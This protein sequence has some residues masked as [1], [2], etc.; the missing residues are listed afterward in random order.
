M[1]KMDF[2]RV[3][4]SLTILGLLLLTAGSCE[5]EEEGGPSIVTDIDGNIYN[6]VTIGTQV[7]MVENLK[8]TR[9]RDGSGIPNVTDNLQWVSDGALKSPAYCNL[10]NYEANSTSYGRLYNWYA[11]TDNRNICPVG[12]RVPTD[13]D[14]TVLTEYLGGSD[15][16]GGKLKSSNGWMSPNFGVED[17]TGFLAFPGGYRD[18]D[19]TFKRVFYVN[20][21]VMG[22][23]GYWWTETEYDNDNGFAR[24]MFSD[25]Y[26]ALTYQADKKKGFSVRCIKNN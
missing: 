6:T 5:D 3:I 12:W 7:W 21:E 8:T 9:F 22:D 19:G 11:V 20:G 16:A 24:I 10:D 13:D 17:R 4:S 18:V 14:W 26:S 23:F 25:L 1:N 2:I 15:I